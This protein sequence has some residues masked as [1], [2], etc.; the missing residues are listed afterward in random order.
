MPALSLLARHP[1]GRRLL[2]PAAGALAFALFLML[3]FPYETL[4]RRIEVEAQRGGAEVTIGS[5]GP[6]FGGVR[7]RD[8][9]VHFSATPGADALP[10]FRFDS[11]DVSPDLFALL[12]RRTSFGFALAGYGGTAKGHLAM[13]SDP[14]QP[15]LSS[16]RLDARDIDLQTLPLKDFGG[17][18]A[19]GK[20]QLKVDLASLIPAETAGGAVTLSL[21]GGSVT[22]GSVQ[23]FP[24]PKTSLGRVEGSVSVE[25]GVARLE[26]TSARGGDLD[27]DVDGTVSL[28]PLLS[29]SQAELHVRFRPS[30]K[31]LDANAMIKGA[32]GLL[33]NARQGDGSYL[34]TFTGPLARMTPR[35]GK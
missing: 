35:P 33:Q 2:L 7:A 18:E 25:K 27:A 29:L 28:R 32:M 8:V 30:D 34:F 24:V 20:L 21:D 31:W 16:L 17:V 12:L 26:K 13:S 10:E 4:A 3:T 15:G 14:K 9:K 6:A 19:S 22:S 11:L 5:M 23:G 1:R